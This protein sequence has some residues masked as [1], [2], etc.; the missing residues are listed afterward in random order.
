VMVDDVIAPLQG[1]VGDEV[2][3]VASKVYH[4]KHGRVWAIKNKQNIL[5]LKLLFYF[6]NQKEQ[7]DWFFARFVLFHFSIKTKRW[8]TPII[9]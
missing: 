6:W 2:T 9:F 5:F 4:G 7:F 8:A 3:D 1:V